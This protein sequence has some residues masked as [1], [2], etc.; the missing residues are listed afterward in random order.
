[1]RRWP[2]KAENLLY[3]EY[4]I[5]Q[6]K[7]GLLGA[8]TTLIGML[9]L[10]IITVTGI[11]PKSRGLLLE[12]HS[13]GKVQALLNALN[14]VEAIKVTAFRQPTLLDRIALRHGKRLDM[15]EVNPP[16]YR[17]VREELGVL[18]DFLGDTIKE[19]GN[20]VIGIRGMPR[21]GKTEAAIAACVY[22][23]KRWILLSST[24]IRQALRTEL[25]LDESVNSIFLIDGITSTTRG[26]DGHWALLEKTLQMPTLK[27]IEHPDIF[28]RDGRL[29]IDLDF[30]IEIRHHQEDVIRLEDISMSFTAFDMS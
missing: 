22:A 29:K 5:Q 10:N 26:T 24:I 23:N 13:E 16:T 20:Q 25:L 9:G 6:N 18:V 28:L 12:T 15:V 4:D 21:V 11:E 27:I 3:L 19:G 17:F 1:M 14:E 8:V 7:P 2:N 30:I